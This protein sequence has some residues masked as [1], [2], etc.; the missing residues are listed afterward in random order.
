LLPNFEKFL[1]NKEWTSTRKSLVGTAATLFFSLKIS[2]F[3]SQKTF[4]VKDAIL[5]NSMSPSD[6]AVV[7]PLPTTKPTTKNLRHY[8]LLVNLIGK[9]FW[10]RVSIKK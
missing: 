8:S 9:H 5:L 6:C 4:S 2:L 1:R 7:L 10:G 3:D